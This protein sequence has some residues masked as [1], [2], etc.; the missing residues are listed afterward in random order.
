MAS[1]APQPW[2]T[3]GRVGILLGNLA[4]SIGAFAADFNETHVYNPK[5][6]S[7]HPL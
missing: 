2:F 4:Y 6:Y 5:W 1:T 7:S 3:P